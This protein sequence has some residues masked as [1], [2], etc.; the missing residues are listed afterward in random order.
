M[1][2]IIKEARFASLRCPQCVAT[3]AGL[4]VQLDDSRLALIDNEQRLVDRKRAVETWHAKLSQQQAAIAR[5]DVALKRAQ[6]GL[7][8]TRLVAPFDGFLLDVEA[9]RFVLFSEC[10]G[11]R[12]PNVP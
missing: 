11:H 10:D 9:D 12:Q 6:R 5:L 2:E 3:K 7:E 4:L 1:N 8:E